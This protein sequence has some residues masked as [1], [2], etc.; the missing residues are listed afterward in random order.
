M[1]TLLPCAM[2][3]DDLRAAARLAGVTPLPAF[4]SGWAAEEL[5]VADAVAVR[6]L[7]ARGLAEARDTDVA[8]TESAR[9]ALDPLLSPDTL[10]EILRDAGPAGRR[11][12][13]LG[14]SANGMVLAAER[15]P[16][17]WELRAAEPPAALSVSGPL[18]PPYERAVAT[19]DRFVVGGEALDRAETLLAQ[20][21]GERLPAL[22]RGD[23]LDEPDAASLA[24]ILSLM[25]V[26]VTVRTVSRSGDSRTAD[27]LTWLDAG[28]AGLWTV[29]PAEDGD[30]E[31]HETHDAAYTVTAADHESVHDALTDLL[32]GAL[33]EQPCLMS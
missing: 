6:G 22:L 12:H 28:T 31:P 27:A 24:E 7:L 1:T 10:V 23:G 33:E 4:E 16:S 18:I 30:D 9:H 19:R 32:A 29:A 26:L 17:I 13:V 14:R 15:A 25:R 2:S 3:S 20:G 8:L 11:G 21:G 5:G